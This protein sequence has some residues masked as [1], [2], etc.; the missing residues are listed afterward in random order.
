MAVVWA[1]KHGEVVFDTIYDGL[2]RRH[3]LRQTA[4]STECQESF[5]ARPDPEAPNR[6]RQFAE[7]FRLIVKR[8]PFERKRNDFGRI[9]LRPLPRNELDRVRF[10]VAWIVAAK[11]LVEEVLVPSVVALN[12]ALLLF[13]DDDVFKSAQIFVVTLV[14]SFEP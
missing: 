9:I 4:N 6:L 13:A 12:F 5:D 8:A 10:A 7:L 3:G 1:A 2:F 11:S 14:E